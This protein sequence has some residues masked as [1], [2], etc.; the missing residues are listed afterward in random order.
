MADFANEIEIPLQESRIV[1]GRIQ[2]KSL[3]FRVIFNL[4]RIALADSG[5]PLKTLTTIRQIKEKYRKTMGEE[6][7]SKAAKVGDRYYWRFGTPGFPS[8]ALNILHKNEIKRLTNQ[9]EPFGL[10]TLFFAITSTCK[11][12]CEHCFEGPAI[13]HTKDLAI[14]ELLQT[15]HKYQNY[16]TTQI[17]F[18]GGEP[19]LRLKDI[20]QILE[21]AYEGTD[22][23]IITSGLGLDLPAAITL[24]EKGLTGAM[25][26]LDSHI[27]SE[28]DHFRGFKGAYNAAIHAVINANKAGLV[29]TLSIC[30]T[31]DYLKNGG[32]E[33]YM[34]L[35]KKLGATFVQVIEPKAVGRYSG[36]DVELKEDEL[37][38]LEKTYLKY[39]SD[40][41]YKNY[42][43][44]NYIGY[45]QRRIGCF[46]G[47]NRFF[48]ID[49]EGDAHLCPYCRGKICSVIDNNPEDV[50]SLLKTHACHSYADKKGFLF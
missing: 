39:N 10:R 45:H 18:S 20:Y 50:I 46:G 3:K 25:V 48:Y 49:P 44:V 27:E 17:M 1:K 9:K 22:F 43:I 23:W 12:N 11:M 2:L 42:P 37:E 29:T 5:K 19:L 15:V 30:P 7:L 16:R 38:K 36:K 21:E 14:S 34:E 47:G 28:H 33:K 35:A 13:N 24:K 8:K 4:L 40:V 26:S 31:H 41:R 32:M 6:L